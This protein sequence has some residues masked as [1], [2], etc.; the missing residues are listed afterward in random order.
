MERFATSE[1]MKMVKILQYLQNVFQ[2]KR[3]IH[4]LWEPPPPPPV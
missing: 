4:V 3:K 1:M 2:G